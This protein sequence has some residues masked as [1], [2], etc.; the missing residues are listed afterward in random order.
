MHFSMD[1][2]DLSYA[3]L[4]IALLKEYEKRAA[5]D[6]A[7]FLRWFLE[8]IY[9]QDPQPLLK[10]KQDARVHRSIV[11]CAARGQD[12]CTLRRNGPGA[13]SMVSYAPHTTS[14][15]QLSHP[16]WRLRM[17]HQLRQP[18]IQPLNITTKQLRSQR[19][20]ATE[21]STPACTT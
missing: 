18:L 1:V 15:A 4:T 10:P 8:N 13:P 16:S 7:R 17:L 20:Q 9:R 6:S 19:H 14:I 21:L 2:E 3:S 11:G 5:T 12:A